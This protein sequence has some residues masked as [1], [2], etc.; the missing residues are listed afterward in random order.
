MTTLL[1]WLLPRPLLHPAAIEEADVRMREAEVREE[2]ARAN[3]V[4]VRKQF[5]PRYVTPRSQEI[6]R[7]AEQLDGADAEMRKA[8]GD[9]EP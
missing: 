1:R 2:A 6:A 8:L 9:D 7:L 4:R 5:D 3:L